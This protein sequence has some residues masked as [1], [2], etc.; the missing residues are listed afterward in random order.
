[1][2]ADVGAFSIANPPAT[3]FDVPSGLQSECRTS[4]G[5][6]LATYPP[7]APALPNSGKL[8]RANP[9]R[10]LHRRGRQADWLSSLSFRGDTALIVTLHGDVWKLKDVLKPSTDGTEER[11]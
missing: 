2:T 1:V 10:Q 7:A 9:R 11:R 8:L 4:Q 6:S 3:A 5:D